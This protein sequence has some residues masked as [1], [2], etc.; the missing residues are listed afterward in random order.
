MHNIFDCKR[1]IIIIID[2]YSDSKTLD[3]MCDLFI[4]VT[5]FIEIM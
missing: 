5:N 3:L 1:C 2:L 4:N